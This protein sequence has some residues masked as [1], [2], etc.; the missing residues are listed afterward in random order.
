MRINIAVLI[1]SHNRKEKTISCLKNLTK[2]EGRNYEFVLEI[3][4]F[5]D[6]SIDNTYE[7]IQKEYPSINLFKG[8]GT[9]YWNG[10]MRF[11]MSK[12]INKHYDYVFWLND[13][14]YLF[15][16]AIQT[17]IDTH[18]SANHPNTTNNILVGLL[19]SPN[20]E[21]ITYGGFRRISKINP[22]KIQLVSSIGKPQFVDTMN[23]NCVLIPYSVIKKNGNLDSAYVHSKGDIDYG[24]RAHEKGIGIVTTS[25]VVGI[26]RRDHDYYKKLKSH[27][28]LQRL[29]LL[30]HPKSDANPKET[31]IFMK[32][33]GGPLWFL[34]YIY[35][36]LALF[37][38]N[39]PTCITKSRPSDRS[40]NS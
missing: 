13:D 6:G 3:F 25:E 38:P 29:K 19:K 32:R 22:L 4:V 7:T 14:T 8:D 36:Y 28:P 35:Y 27:P 11:L 5:D 16:N 24:F 26:C 34:F 12:V 18:A 33:H 20:S 37:L 23:G 39:K 15:P 9:Y 40:M 30:F 1:T 17:L 31:L 21:K 2:Q 10:G